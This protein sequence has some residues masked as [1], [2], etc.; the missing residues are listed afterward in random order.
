MDLFPGL[1]PTAGGNESAGF[2]AGAAAGNALLSGLP[3]QL[4]S[5]AITTDDAMEILILNMYWQ[6]V[7]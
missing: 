4:A 5:V 7:A 1:M 3:A 6:P 2:G